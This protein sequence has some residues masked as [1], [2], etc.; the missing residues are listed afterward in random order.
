MGFQDG[1]PVAACI[2][3]RCLLH[4]HAFESERTTIFDHIIEGINSALKVNHF[5]CWANVA[6]LFSLIY[7]YLFPFFLI[8][9]RALVVFFRGAIFTKFPLGLLRFF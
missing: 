9:P 3:Y 7:F 1:K 2:I 5:W 6:L 8:P 4:W